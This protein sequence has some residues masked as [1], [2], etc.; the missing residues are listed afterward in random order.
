MKVFLISEFTTCLKH[1]NCI[2]LF[3]VHVKKISPKFLRL[4]LFSFY[5]LNHFQ[6]IWLQTS[7]IWTHSLSEA[8]LSQC[9]NMA[10]KMAAPCGDPSPE[11]SSLP[12]P[13]RTAT[14][15]A[16]VSGVGFTGTNDPTFIPALVNCS[17]SP[18]P[19]VMVSWAQDNHSNCVCFWGQIYGSTID[20][21]GPIEAQTPEVT[22]S[23]GRGHRKWWSR[24]CHVTWWRTC[25][26]SLVAG[27]FLRK[28]MRGAYRKLT[29]AMIHS[30][31]Q[32]TKSMLV[33]KSQR[34]RV[35]H[36]ARQQRMF[37]QRICL[38]CHAGIDQKSI[39]HCVAKQATQIP[40]LVK[41]DAP[42]V[43]RQQVIRCDTALHN[44]RWWCVE[45]KRLLFSEY[46][47]ICVCTSH[48]LKQSP[49]CPGRHLG[50]PF[51]GIHQWRDET[52]V[53][54]GV[55]YWAKLELRLNPDA[56][57]FLLFYFWQWMRELYY[58]ESF[59]HPWESEQLY[60][61]CVHV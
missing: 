24:D 9:F 56:I 55:N 12:E 16:G 5:P 32:H 54:E 8:G 39:P 14:V 18:T 38:R 4:T 2:F 37:H 41:A 25:F 52:S 46:E 31:L 34:A 19:H 10:A 26:S 7:W 13:A 20:S 17:P 61:G 6:D 44:S 11:P 50:D 1:L 51:P 23:P 45:Q 22:K 58:E 3:T 57:P 30:I 21:R 42:G 40:A 47:N 53:R 59:N 35:W 49:R 48:Q 28:T 36:R 15:F 33:T 43:L 27:G 60:P 29:M